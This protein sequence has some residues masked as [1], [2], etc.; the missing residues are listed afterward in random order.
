MGIRSLLKLAVTFAILNSVL[1]TLALAQYQLKDDPTVCPVKKFK[2]GKWLEA[3]ASE[4]AGTTYPLKSFAGSSGQSAIVV[5]GVWYSAPTNCF[6]NTEAVSTETKPEQKVEPKK[7]PQKQSKTSSQPSSKPVFKKFGVELVGSYALPMGASLKARSTGTGTSQDNASAFM[8]GALRGAYAL[9]NKIELLG[10]VS[11]ISGTQNL[12]GASNTVKL[13]HVILGFG[14]SGR[15]YF[16]DSKLK[17]FG[18]AGLDYSSLGTKSSAGAT[19]TS[20]AGLGLGLGAG[21]R[22]SFGNLFSVLLGVRYQ[23]LTITKD[24]LAYKLDTLPIDLG[25]RFSF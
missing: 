24:N 3:T 22:Y 13:T 17:L 15:Y 21:A 5:N 6:L 7:T 19:L 2:G 4:T 25:V 14:A 8:G 9:N 12:I 23:L 1:P 20:M 10:T 11:Y 18:E 16:T